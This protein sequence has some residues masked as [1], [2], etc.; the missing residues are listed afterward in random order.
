[1][2]TKVKPLVKSLKDAGYAIASNRDSAMSIASYVNEQCPDFLD[3][4]PDEIVEQLVSGFMVRFH[5]NR[6]DKHYIRADGNL[7]P[8]DAS[9]AGATVINVHVAFGYTQQQF[10][11][12]KGEDPSFH[13]VIGAVRDAFNKYKKDCLDSLKNAI[14]RIVN[15]GATRQRGANDNYIDALHKM[16]VTFDTRSLNAK[17]RGD[18]TADQVKFRIARDAF[19]KAYTGN[20]FKA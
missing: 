15:N 19:W 11:K 5:E 2:N 12:L 18:D 7:V 9:T 13:G 1:M 20:E 10:G 16:L 4:A 14:R 17:K 6:G 3:N 8:C